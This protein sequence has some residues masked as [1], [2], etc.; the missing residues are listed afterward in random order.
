MSALVRPPRA[1]CGGTIRVPGDKSVS[2]RV[3]MFGALASGE[4]TASG[5]APGADVQSSASVL[6]SLGVRVTLTPDGRAQISG[7]GASGFSAPDGPLDCGNSG[8]TMRLMM[9][10]LAGQSFDTTLI[11]DESL[12]ARP[13]GRISRPLSGMGARFDLT[14]GKPPVVVRG[15]PLTGTRYD[16]PMA[17]AQ[18]KSAVLLAGLQA[19][20]VTQVSE[21]ALSRDH[22]E[23]MLSAMGAS[24]EVDASG[25]IWMRPGALKPL[26]DFAVPGDLSSAAFLLACG[27]LLDGQGLVLE[28]VGI[29]PTRTGVLDALLSMGAHIEQ[30]DVRDA[31]EPTATLTARRS[32]LKPLDLSGVGVVRAID[33]VPIL[34]V[35]CTQ[36]HGR[37]VIR[38]AGELRVKECDR[39]AATAGFLNDMG[40]RVEELDDGLIIHG[41]TPLR[42]GAAIQPQH[43]HRIAMAGAIAALVADG[44]TTLEDAGCAAVSYP[45]FYADLD[46]C[47]E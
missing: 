36:A 8:T 22:T 13:M 16:S 23:R 3:L 27:V 4:T 42:G 31:A 35:L 41:P 33:E 9:G 15:G 21:P 25:L 30:S 14:D 20:G 1:S 34:A 12:S 11:G 7:V 2:H 19:A 47:T 5:M 45:D 26:V 18:V 43:D 46:R 6:R 37:S 39:L 28:G 29:N 17:S 10:I 38:D 32:E 40:A 44:D 24:L